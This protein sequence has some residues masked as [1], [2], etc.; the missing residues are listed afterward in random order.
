[1]TKFH[2]VRDFNYN[3]DQ[4]LYLR[5]LTIYNIC[6]FYIRI[7]TMTC[8]VYLILTYNKT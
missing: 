5:T 4:Y 8:F 6:N 7:N 3:Y 1:M 2:P